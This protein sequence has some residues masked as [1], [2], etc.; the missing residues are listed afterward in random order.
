[1]GMV[2]EVPKWKSLGPGITTWS[3]ALHEPVWI[4]EQEKILY[5]NESL[6]FVTRYKPVL[7]NTRSSVM[8]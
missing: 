2:G 8:V 3:A 7:T 5:Y 4:Y 1:M 6:R